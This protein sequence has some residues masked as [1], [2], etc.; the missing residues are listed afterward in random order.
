MISKS[1][2]RKEI[3]ELTK[4]IVKRVADD[5]FSDGSG[6][7]EIEISHGEVLELEQIE[8]LHMLS[9]VTVNLFPYSIFVSVTGNFSRLLKWQF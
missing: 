8:V 3:G 5:R 7:K 9:P 6:E 2:L 4:E 1:Q